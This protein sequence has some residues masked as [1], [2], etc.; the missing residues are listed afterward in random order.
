M[1]AKVIAVTAD[2][3]GI[4]NAV[5]SDALKT[6]RGPVFAYF[7]ARWCPD[8][9]RSTPL[10][11]ATFEKQADNVTLV[12][13]DIGEKAVYRDKTSSLRTQLAR[14]ELACLPTLI[15]VSPTSHLRLDSELESC[16][17]VIKGQM[18]VDDFVGKCLPRG[19][20]EDP[21]KVGLLCALVAG[22]AIVV[23]RASRK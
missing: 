22:L 13:V 17:D 16:D 18:M 9:T 8:C 1:P 12:T 4:Q 2:A 3:A 10:V 11:H 20:L 15:C 14:H 23:V 6:G 21:V 19:V 7:M 5:L